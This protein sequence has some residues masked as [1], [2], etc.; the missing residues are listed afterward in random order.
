M[1]STVK[2]HKQ[3]DVIMMGQGE[4]LWTA[5]SWKASLRRWPWIEHQEGRSQLHEDNEEECPRK[6]EWLD[7][8]NSCV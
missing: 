4:P 8:M 1:V 7:R 2:K 6:M 3:N 5:W